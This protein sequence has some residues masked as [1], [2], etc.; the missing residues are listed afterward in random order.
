MRNPC[1]VLEGPNRWS[2]GRGTGRGKR[3]SGRSFPQQPAQG[4]WGSA[5]SEASPLSSP[6]TRHSWTNPQVHSSLGVTDSLGISTAGESHVGL[7]PMSRRGC[8]CLHEKVPCREPEGPGPDPTPGKWAYPS[9]ET[10]ASGWPGL[11]RGLRTAS[12]PPLCF[13]G[14]THCHL[15][16]PQPS[17]PRLLGSPP[18]PSGKIL[19]GFCLLKGLDRC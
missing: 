4:S 9:R 13:P 2:Q 15:T 17:P 11:A 8:Q 19:P 7:C 3:S 16:A 5:H 12:S 14:Q 10:V 18:F 6:E 1:Q